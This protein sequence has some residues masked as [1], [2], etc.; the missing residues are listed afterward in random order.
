MDCDFAKL[1]GKGCLPVSVVIPCFCNENTLPRAIKSIINQTFLPEQIILIDDASSDGTPL[2]FQH[3]SAL[4]SG[5]I[6]ISIILLKKNFGAAY[7]RNKGWSLAT[8]TYVAF[9]DA[10]DSWHPRKLEVQCRLMK[11]YPEIGICGSRHVVT[12]GSIAELKALSLPDIRYITF[13]DLL[14]SNRFVT[15]SIMIRRDLPLRFPER[16]RYME[17]HRLWLEFASSGCRMLRIETPLVAHHK[18]D[19]GA[20]GLSANL[21]A[22]EGAELSNY[23]ALLE[24]SRISLWYFWLICAWSLVK[25]V[26]R[27]VIVSFRR[28]IS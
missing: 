2:V 26:R 3:I 1:S 16:Q 20:G 12:T 5:F 21:R 14:W 13:H 9:L 18:A 22:M 17:D 23:R 8:G 24:Q 11:S 4:Y 10:D 6:S 25:Y 15:S 28:M 19:F 7:A 27:F